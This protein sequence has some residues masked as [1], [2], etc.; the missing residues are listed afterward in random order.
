VWDQSDSYIYSSVG[1]VGFEI[2]E[3]NSLEFKS[4]V[5]NQD[6]LQS[7][8]IPPLACD[9]NR[10]FKVRMFYK[11]DGEN[12]VYQVSNWSAPVTVPCFPPAA[13]S[14]EAVLT[15]PDVNLPEYIYAYYY[16]AAYPKL[17][18]ESSE[19]INHT[20]SES[21]YCYPINLDPDGDNA[22]PYLVWDLGETEAYPYKEFIKLAAIDAGQLGF[23]VV[24]HNSL[25][26]QE[27]ELTEKHYLFAWKIPPQACDGYRIFKMRF[28]YQ[29]GGEH[30]DGD[31]SVGKWSHQVFVPCDATSP[32]LQL[33]FVDA[34]IDLPP[35]ID[36][37]MPNI[38][39]QV[40][41]DPDECVN[42][43]PP[44]AQNLAGELLFCWPYD[45]FDSG[46]DGVNPQ[47]YLIW[48]PGDYCQAQI[49]WFFTEGQ[50]P[51]SDSEFSGCKSYAELLYHANSSYANVGFEIIEFNSSEFRTY[52]VNEDDL[53][54]MPIPPLFCTGERTFKVRM[55]YKSEGVS[56]TYQASPWSNPVT[57]PCGY[58]LTSTRIDVSIETLSFSGV[59]DGESEP[60]DIEVFGDFYISTSAGERWLVFAQSLFLE[61]CPD[62][63]DVGFGL[64]DWLDLDDFCSSESGKS[65]CNN[66]NSSCYK[67]MSNGSFDLSNMA[68]CEANTSAD[69]Q[70]AK[71]GACSMGWQLGNNTVRLFVND[72][73][74]L[75]VNAFLLDYD[76]N[77][78]P[79][80]ACKTN[81][82]SDTYTALQWGAMDG[83]EWEFGSIHEDAS[84]LVRI[85]VSG[86]PEGG[87]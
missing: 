53:T 15:A 37:T 51:W 67:E 7:L 56:P 23:E 42:H 22:Q 8:V 29:S 58:P 27:Y 60:Q 39:A 86:V 13:V 10:T 45:G 76:A 80:W 50:D 46:P 49:D 32:I 66:W 81:F 33:P 74:D 57:V 18:Y 40:T 19:C 44:H 16:P 70:A 41:Y 79:E 11:Q 72:N 82:N 17:T 4:Y 52:Q 43:I 55:F 20:P 31:L 83:Q 69:Y 75:F 3:H 9:G 47:P 2:V 87:E 5:I 63:D 62:D 71:N 34:D 64:D 1:Y 78:L 65:V 61:D 85:E 59:D 73:D 28:F 24:E 14:K 6:D 68:M 48:T 77:S 36:L 54:S 38:E 25:G 21:T 84:C 12:P 26:Y 30:W 35:A